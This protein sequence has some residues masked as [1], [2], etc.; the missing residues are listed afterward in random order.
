M[1]TVQIKG[2]SVAYIDEGQGEVLFLIHGFCGSS[3]YWSRVVPLLANQYRVIAIDLPG[4]GESEVQDSVNQ[5]DNYADFIH[6]FLDS[7]ELDKVTMLGH[8]LGG[9]ITLA[10]AEKY[11]ERLN[12]FSLIHSTGFPDSE[13]AKKGRDTSALKI[14]DEGIEVFVDGLIPKLFAPNNV[15]SHQ[16]LVEEAIKI[17]YST[18]PIGAKNALM[19][20]RDRKDRRE[21]I[22]ITKLPVVL[23]AGA[24]DQLI[25]SEKTFTANGVNI[26]Q[27]VLKDVGHMSMYEAPK[28]LVK[29]FE[30]R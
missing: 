9:Y 5:I 10:F 18:S 15:K 17:G 19:A 30:E 12:G 13:E 24:E 22:N 23:V 29:I 28:E 20:M 3:A 25:P 11:S 27:V 4:H 16:N 6:Q 26:K 14:D 7:L 1:K 21:I 8:S 2:S